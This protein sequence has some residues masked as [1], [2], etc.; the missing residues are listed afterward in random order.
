MLLGKYLEAGV[1]TTVEPSIGVVCAC[2]PTLRPLAQYISLRFANNQKGNRYK[3]QLDSFGTKAKGIKPSNP[4]TWIDDNLNLRPKNQILHKI[5]VS[6][7]KLEPDAERDER[8]LPG[9]LVSH[10]VDVERASA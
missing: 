3:I 5:A 9:I 1:W 4:H 10:D 8:L 2:L 7:A 6:S